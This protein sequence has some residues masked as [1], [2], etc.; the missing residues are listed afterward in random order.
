M[1]VCFTISG[2]PKIASIS[3]GD[4]YAMQWSRFH[5]EPWMKLTQLKDPKDYHQKLVK[6]LQDSFLMYHNLLPEQIISN[7]WILS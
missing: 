6:F 1:K 3:R 5:G 2:V 4:L 7:L